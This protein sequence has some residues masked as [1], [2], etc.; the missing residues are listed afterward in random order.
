MVFAN[1]SLSG[2]TRENDLHAGLIAS[3]IES[4]CQKIVSM[5]H[6]SV[7]LIYSSFPSFPETAERRTEIEFTSAFDLSDQSEHWQNIKSLLTDLERG[8]EPSHFSRMAALIEPDM[9]DE[10]FFR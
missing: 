7:P 2:P 3:I 1:D 5:G 6:E 8:K 9:L 10:Y 4:I